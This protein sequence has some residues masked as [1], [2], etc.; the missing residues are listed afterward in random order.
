MAA[1][2]QGHRETIAQHRWV[3]IS[4]RV[5]I[6]YPYDPYPYYSYYPYP[7]YPC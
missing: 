2:G 6:P 5:R 4:C 1:R 7:Y 3:R